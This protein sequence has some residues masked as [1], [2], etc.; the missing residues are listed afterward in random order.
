MVALVKTL[1]SL[2]ESYL[3]TFFD[4][5]RQYLTS[6]V[7]LAI[8]AV[9]VGLL[10]GLGQYFLLKFARNAAPSLKTSKWNTRTA[11]GVRILQ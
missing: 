2:L 9:Q 7:G 5:S 1:D 4:V 8:L 11:I 6:N 10:Y 3:S